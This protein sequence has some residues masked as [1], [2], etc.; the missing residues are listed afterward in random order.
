M[1]VCLLF[2]SYF[3]LSLKQD[4]AEE[5]Y[6]MIVLRSFLVGISVGFSV[7][8]VFILAF[9]RAALCGFWT[10]FST[11]LGAVCADAL[12][13]TLSLLGILSLVSK[14]KGFVFFLDVVAAFLL[15]GLSFSY[16]M[17]DKQ[18]FQ[19]DRACQGAFISSL[20]QG[21]SLTLFNPLSFFFF[22]AVT[23]YILPDTMQT[24]A[25]PSILPPVAALSLG[26]L[27]VLSSACAV[28]HF[29]GNSMSNSALLFMQKGAAVLFFIGGCYLFAHSFLTLQDLKF[30]P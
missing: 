16:F 21:F 18:K 2:T 7:G 5:G 6:G 26:S 13:F 14:I 27:G 23:L 1:V 28:A 29:V 30:S 22:M 12:Y 4:K 15:W 25:L 3:L 8:P 20:I 17:A 9:N 11:A 10:G 24:L 19:E